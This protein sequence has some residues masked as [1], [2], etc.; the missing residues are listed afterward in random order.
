MRIAKRRPGIDESEERS[1]SDDDDLDESYDPFDQRK[2]PPKLLRDDQNIV[3]QPRPDP[4]N[5]K[6]RIS[7]F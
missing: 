3:D 2:H 1:G 5:F 7:M 6:R 4:M